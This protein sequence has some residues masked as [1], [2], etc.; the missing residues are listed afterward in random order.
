MPVST[1]R[2]ASMRSAGMNDW[3]M[4]DPSSELKRNENE[5]DRLD[6]DERQ[7]DTAD[8]V[9]QHISAQ[10][11]AGADRPILDAAKRQRNQRRDD[12]RVEDDRR[13]NRGGGCCELH[14]VER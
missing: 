13:Q 3:N 14:D 9:D 8:A 11:R 5:V 7:H 12:E 4:M 2:T 6:A 10:D 1:E